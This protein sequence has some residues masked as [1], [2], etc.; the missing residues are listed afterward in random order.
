MTLDEL[1]ELIKKEFGGVTREG[2][3]SWRESYQ[4]D[5]GKDWPENP[6]WDDEGSTWM[7]V[8]ED[9]RW[10][11]ELG[12]G[13]WNFLDPIGM[14][15]YLPAGMVRMLRLCDDIGLKFQLTFEGWLSIA[16]PTLDKGWRP[17]HLELLAD[18]QMRVVGLYVD[19][20]REIELRCYEDEA[21]RKFFYRHSWER[22]IDLYWKIWL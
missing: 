22:A 17:K 16:K 18:D 19:K 3:V 20:M 21:E 9:D 5:M 14:R 11:P 1:I 2:G 4:I 10:E 8:A 12:V 6:R 13:G 15:F 7:E